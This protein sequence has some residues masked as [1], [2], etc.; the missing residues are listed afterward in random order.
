MSTTLD[1]K[2][3]VLKYI[4][5]TFTVEQMLKCLT[6]LNSTAKPVTAGTP[7]IKTPVIKTPAFTVPREY[8]EKFEESI[9]ISCSR[10]VGIFNEFC[11]NK[12]LKEQLLL[13]L[14]N[15]NVTLVPL[16]GKGDARQRIIDGLNGST[17]ITTGKTTPKKNCLTSAQMKKRVKEI[18]KHLKDNNSLTKGKGLGSEKEKHGQIKKGKVKGVEDFQVAIKIFEGTTGSHEISILKALQAE[19][20]V[21]NFYKSFQVEKQTILVSELVDGDSLR[22]LIDSRKLSDKEMIS[23]MKQILTGLQKLQKKYK[24]T[25]NDLHSANILIQKVC[26]T[27][28]VNK[29]PTLGNLVK[30]WDFNFSNIKGNPT[31][32]IN[33]PFGIRAEFS[34]FYDTYLVV[35]DWKLSFIT[36]AKKTDAKNYPKVLKFLKSVKPIKNAMTRAQATARILN[37]QSVDGTN[38]E[39]AT[40]LKLL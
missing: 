32:E 37:P 10:D 17:P 20:C 27:T 12:E 40:L 5:T 31:Q 1:T 4:E 11:K 23:I 33:Y 21:V 13:L 18:Q 39:P 36:Y 19:N 35:E 24:F 9:Q 8:A 6:R 16:K 3:K 14:H 38:Y 7:K 30:F 34:S 2:E 22:G 25:H 29:I 15:N 28:V 26:K